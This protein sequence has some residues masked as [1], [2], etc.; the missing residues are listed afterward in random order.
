MTPQ[1][2]RALGALTVILVVLGA[3][4]VLVALAGQASGQEAATATPTPEPE[5]NTT[6]VEQV[7][8]D[9]RVTDYAYLEGEQL[10]TVTLENTG[11]DTSHVTI[12]EAISR[13]AADSG[14][15]GIKSLRVSAGETVTVELTVYTDRPIGVMV[16][17]RQSVEQGHGTFLAIEDDGID[18]IEGGATWSDVRAG[19]I[20][21]I[22]STL[23]IIGLVA[24][25][26]V[27]SKNDDVEDVEVTA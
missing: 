15:F 3:T 13:E 27:A 18:L 4:G 20:A 26:R 16:T 22:L 24:W 21:G 6:V 2:R 1:T 8:E 19:G 7:D 10:F 11:D 17:S 23:L 25:H 12:T 5:G 14:R 9:L